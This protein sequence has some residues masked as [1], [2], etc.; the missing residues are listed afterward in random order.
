MYSVISAVR[1]TVPSALSENCC[2]ISLPITNPV[3]LESCNVRAT[4]YPV[5]SMLS[6]VTT[7]VSRSSPLYSNNSQNN[8]YTGTFF[9]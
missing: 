4:S 8:L 9:N 7:L 1:L 5:F 2:L 6:M 3:A